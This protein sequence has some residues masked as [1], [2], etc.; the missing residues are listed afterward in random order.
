MSMW[1]PFTERARDFFGRQSADLAQRQ[2]D[3]RVGRQGR[4]TTREDEPKAIIL[5]FVIFAVALR[6]LITWVFNNVRGS[7]LLVLLLHTSYNAGFYLLPSLVRLV[8]VNVYLVFVVVAM[9]II[10]AT[11]GRLS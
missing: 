1:E 9:L 2:R 6:F 4:M 11:R 8:N 5:E 10:A 3:A 7:L